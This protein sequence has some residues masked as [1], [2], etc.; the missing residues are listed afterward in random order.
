MAV[1]QFRGCGGLVRGMRWLRLGNAVAVTQFRGCGGS[2][3]LGLKVTPY[4]K[5]SSPGFEVTAG[6]EM[7]LCIKKDRI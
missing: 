1:T 5:R 6:Q 3:G 7:L 4:C 2:V